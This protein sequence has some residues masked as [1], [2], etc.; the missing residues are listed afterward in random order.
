[1]AR[2]QTA[3]TNTMGTQTQVLEQAIVAFGNAAQASDWLNTPSIVLGVIPLNFVG[4]EDG[5]EAACIELT[6]IQ[7]GYLV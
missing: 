3:M 1:M 5:L 7:W 2:W 4:T 6:R